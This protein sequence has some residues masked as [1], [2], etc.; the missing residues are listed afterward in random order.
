[1]KQ[2][3]NHKAAKQLVSVLSA[4]LLAA[5][6]LTA[7]G[8]AGRDASSASPAPAASSAV[9]QPDTST[10][11]KETD[12]PAGSTAGEAEKDPVQPSSDVQPSEPGSASEQAPSSSE[13][14]GITAV[15]ASLRENYPGLITVSDDTVLNV[16][17][18]PTTESPIVGKLAKGAGAIDLK[19]SDREGWL[20]I[21]SGQVEGYV[22][23]EFVL[24][25]EE[26]LEKAAK[27]A[28]AEIR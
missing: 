17:Q 20:H 7:Y 28:G 12:I 4:A 18:R 1:M 9:P 22:S 13:D 16:R 25:N 8:C 14:P 23:A 26:A 24:Q 5:A 3:I 2:F 19:D 11:T 10:E 27:A 6:V 15:I 21:R